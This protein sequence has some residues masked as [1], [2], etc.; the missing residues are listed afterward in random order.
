VTSPIRLRPAVAADAQGVGAV[1]DA[2]VRAGWTYLGEISQ[3]PMFPPEEWDADIAA[4]QGPN[5]MLV[6]VDPDGRVVG[7]TA[8]HP[9]DGEMY[10]LFVHPDVAGQGVGRLLLDAAHDELRRAGCTE[11]FLYT[12]EQNER[13]LAVYRAAGYVPDGTVRESDFRGIQLREPRLV[14]HLVENSAR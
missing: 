11:A 7:F 5:L 4:H 9:E 12:H 1:F 13:A 2:A 6:A 10:L 8:V 14:A 3:A